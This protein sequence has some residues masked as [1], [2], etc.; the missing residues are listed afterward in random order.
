M[1]NDSDT[2][3]WGEEY[4]KETVS[5]FK[6]DPEDT[7][8]LLGCRRRDGVIKTTQDE[9][10]QASDSRKRCMERKDEKPLTWYFDIPECKTKSS[11]TIPVS[12]DSE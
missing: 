9:K 7:C 12:L 5:E 3:F 6:S 1:I 10:L 11:K 2:T 8:N 4:E